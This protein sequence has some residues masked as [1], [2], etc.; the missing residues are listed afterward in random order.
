MLERIEKFVMAYGYFTEIYD[1]SSKKVF[2][3][4]YKVNKK[5]L[6]AF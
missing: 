5:V 6:V 4:I 1:H 3:G 2:M